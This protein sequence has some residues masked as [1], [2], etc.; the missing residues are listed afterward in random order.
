[1]LVDIKCY[2]E[3][4]L[5]RGGRVTEPASQL[6]PLVPLNQIIMIRGI[7]GKPSPRNACIP[8]EPAA[9]QTAN[10]YIT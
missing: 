8:T 6:N 7:E 10:M 5:V 9:I 3:H 1:M 2:D 4:R